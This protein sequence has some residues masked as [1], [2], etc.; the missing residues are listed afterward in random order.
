MRFIITCSACFSTWKL[1]NSWETYEIRRSG[2]LPVVHAPSCQCELWNRVSIHLYKQREL[3]GIK[4]TKMR[5]I[6]A[7]S[8]RPKWLSIIMKRNIDVSYCL[9]V[10]RS[11][12]T[13]TWSRFS[14]SW[15]LAKVGL[16]YPSVS[17]TWATVYV[18]AELMS[19]KHQNIS[20]Q[21]ACS[22]S[23]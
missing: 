8:H 19:S 15:F 9:F 22:V 5:C 12:E 18:H 3:I 21:R 13:N 11:P 7:I 20:D 23:S 2:T 6:P 17:G 4:Y 1:R 14:Y 10:K 16:I